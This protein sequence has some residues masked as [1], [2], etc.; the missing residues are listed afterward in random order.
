MIMIFASLPILTVVSSQ[1]THSRDVRIVGCNRTAVA[2]SSKHL[3]RVEAETTR[4]SKASCL[5]LTIPS[6]DRLCRVLDH[7]Q[8]VSIRDREE[9]VHIANAAVQMHWQD[10]FGS[11]SD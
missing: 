10:C 4:N 3:E 5:L 9:S 8:A 11:T 1:A 2:E 7:R 6:A